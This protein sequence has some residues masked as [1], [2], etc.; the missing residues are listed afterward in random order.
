MQKL[1]TNKLTRVRKTSNLNILL[2]KYMKDNEALC[3]DDNEGCPHEI[4]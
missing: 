4:E 3:I 1:G 2:M